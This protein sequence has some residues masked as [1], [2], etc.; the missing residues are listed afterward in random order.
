MTSHAFRCL[1]VLL[2][3]ALSVE[4]AR[5]ED[6]PAFRGPT[7][8][9]HSKAVGLPT[10]WSETENVRWKTAIH[11]KG[12][13]SPVVFGD[14]IWLTTAKADGKELFAVCLDRASGR[15]LHDVKVFEL[16]KPPFCH[17]YNSYASSTPVIEKGRLY[18]HFGTNGTACL[19]TDTGK[20]LW[21]RTD[22][23]CDHFRGAASSPTLHGKHL[24]LIFDGFDTQYVVALDKET[25]KNVW[26]KDRDI[27]Y[28]NAS[29]DEKKAYA[30]PAVL[31]IDGKE[32]LVCP[33]AGATIAYNPADGKELWRY[34]HGGMNAACQPILANGFI[35]I[36]CGYP[37]LVLALKPGGE[38]DVTKTHTGFKVPRSAPTRPGLILSDGLLF[39]VNDAGIASCLDAKT[40]DPVWQERVN[41]AFSASP[42]IADGKIYISDEAGASHV[43]EAG[44][45]YNRIATNKLADGCM[46]SPAV[47]GKCLLMR[48]K[49]H[50]Y[51]IEQK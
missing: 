39:M 37:A 11:D 33:S 5:A 24:Y 34:N 29:G 7:G 16:E 51:C 35:Y 45:K 50:L 2:F 19:D 23:K 32:Q 1:A 10:R 8:D 48:T 47:A 13:S 28:K 4:A 9:G 42:L 17:P 40:G 21:E 22:L 3:S 14:Q 15:I 6:W 12:W 44:K 46:A 49:T 36:T 18:V 25:G 31:T 38:G 30:T 41:G 20:V 26:K 27:Q 43:I